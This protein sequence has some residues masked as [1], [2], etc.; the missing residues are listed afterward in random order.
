MAN[1]AL[2][3]YFKI[4]I[5][6]KRNFSCLLKCRKASR[7]AGEGHRDEKR[8]EGSRTCLYSH[9]K[10]VKPNFENYELSVDRRNGLAKPYRPGTDDGEQSEGTGKTADSAKRAAM[11]GFI[12]RV[13]V[14][15]R[16]GADAAI[17]SGERNDSV[18]L[19]RQEVLLQG[20]GYKSRSGTGR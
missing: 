11:N 5:Y 7:S 20:R 16:N 13:P 2:K 12:R 19:Y 4:A 9:R 18:L 14:S 3:P 1:F 6:E 15:G 17:L 10:L 8:S